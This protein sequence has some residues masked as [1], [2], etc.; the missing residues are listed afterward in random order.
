MTSWIHPAWLRHDIRDVCVFIAFCSL[1]NNFMIRISTVDRW[2]EN[3]A[4]R[5][6]G[7]I[8]D[9]YVWLVDMVAFC[10]LNLRAQ[11]PSMD[12]RWF[13]FARQAKHAF[14]NWRQDRED[15]KFSEMD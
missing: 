8:H 9:F 12:F 11:I 6:Q 15:R 4:P 3:H 13:G 2:A 14:R 1:L 10:G 5:F 7:P